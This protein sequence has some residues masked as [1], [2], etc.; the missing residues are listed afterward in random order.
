L[1]PVTSNFFTCNATRLTISHRV[2]LVCQHLVEY[3]PLD[4]VLLLLLLLLLLL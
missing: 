2:A 4:I 1:N 3:W